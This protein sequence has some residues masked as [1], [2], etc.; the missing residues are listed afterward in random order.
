LDDSIFLYLKDMGSA[1]LAAEQQDL[2]RPAP[3]LIP[4][5]WFVAVQAVASHSLRQYSRMSID[6]P[7]MWRRLIEDDLIGWR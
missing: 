6:D 3:A 5:S 1:A 7:L 4:L 2:A